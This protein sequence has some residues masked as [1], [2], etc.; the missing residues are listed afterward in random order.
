MYP[1]LLTITIINYMDADLLKF[2]LVRY[3]QMKYVES[4]TNALPMVYEGEWLEGK[5]HGIG[6][7]K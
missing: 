1:L 5:M 6:K 2:L 3:G 4:A 7:M